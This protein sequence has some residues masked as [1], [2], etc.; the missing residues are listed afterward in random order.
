MPPSTSCMDREPGSRKRILPWEHHTFTP[1]FSYSSLMFLWGYHTK[2]PLSPPKLLHPDYFRSRVC[3]V[4]QQD[5]ACQHNPS[6]YT[7]ASE[8]V[9]LFDRKLRM[10]L[11]LLT[12]SILHP[13]PLCLRK[14]EKLSGSILWFLG[15]TVNHKSLLLHTCEGVLDTQCRIKSCMN[16]WLIGWIHVKGLYVKT[17]AL[18]SKPTENPANRQLTN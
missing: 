4:F 9:T 18:K 2:Y 12:S 6:A 17:S 10:F 16:V 7:E 8:C 5:Y 3:R 13:G 11:L 14:Q 1:S 15:K